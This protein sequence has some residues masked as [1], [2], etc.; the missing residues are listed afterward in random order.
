MNKFIHRYIL[1][2]AHPVK[3]S[4]EILGIFFSAYFLWLHNWIWAIIASIF[5]FLFSTLLVWKRN[6][7]LQQIENSSL[8]KIMLVYS[9]PLNFFLYNFSAIPL[10]YGLWTHNIFSILLA[11]LILLAPYLLKNLK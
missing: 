3:F 1:S 7:D 5:F 4:A 6:V 2:H 11:I 9:T 10:I 8:G